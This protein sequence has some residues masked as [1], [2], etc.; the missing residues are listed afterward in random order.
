[1]RSQKSTTPPAASGLRR[2]L[3]NLPFAPGA[4]RSLGPAERDIYAEHLTRLDPEC[5]RLRFHRS[6]TDA[7]L[8]AHADA[9]FTE[10]GDA[11]M[12]VIGWFRRGVLRGVGEVA[13]FDAPGAPNGRDAEAAFAVESRWRGKGVGR[14]LL[15]LAALHARN[16]GAQS[17]HISTERGNRAMVRTAMGAGATFDVGATE[18]EGVLYTGPRTVFSVALEWI[19]DEIGYAHWIWDVAGRRIARLWRGLTR[20]SGRPQPLGAAGSYSSTARK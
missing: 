19:E 8:E 12:H 11:E 15:W 5:R 3:L 9:V 4:Y 16:S 1:M 17:L 14:R 18:A 6:M 7:A 2:F 20:R 10:R 13:V